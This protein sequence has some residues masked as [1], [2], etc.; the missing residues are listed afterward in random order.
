MPFEINWE[1]NGV[2]VRFSGTYDYMTNSDA[3][4]E[5]LNDVRFED[6]NYAIWDLSAVSL[7]KLTDA[8]IDLAASYDQIISSRVPR[9]KMA[10]LAQSNATRR[11]AYQYVA[12]YHARHT[13]WDFK[14]SDSMEEIRSWV[15]P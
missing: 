10:L 8:D 14:V 11:M 3:T 9:M 1:N 12:S 6:I 5:V 2:L 4:L 15:C 13:G 7:Q